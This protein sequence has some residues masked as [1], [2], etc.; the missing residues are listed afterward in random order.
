MEHE[1]NERWQSDDRRGGR[2]TYEF[3]EVA[4]GWQT[5]PAMQD[6]RETHLKK[7]K[8]MDEDSEFFKE[9]MG[10]AWDEWLRKKNEAFQLYL[11]AKREAEKQYGD[12][13][14]ELKE[15]DEPTEEVKA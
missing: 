14:L 8:Q 15:M 7:V 4:C 5:I 2:G 3:H 13:Y 10:K 12:R 11:K 6:T 9:E 1:P